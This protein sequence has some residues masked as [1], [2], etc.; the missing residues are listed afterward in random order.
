MP[1][2]VA[3]FL[4]V[5]GLFL[6]TVFTV[7][8]S[9]WNAPLGRDDAEEVTATYSS[10]RIDYDYDRYGNRRDIQEVEL[11]F[12]DHDE[13][14]IDGSCVSEEVKNAIKELPVGAELDMLLHP[15]S[16]SIVELKHGEKTILPFEEAVKDLGVE[17]IGFLILG[18]LLYLCA[19]WGAFVLLKRWILK[20]KN[21][22][23]LIKELVDLAGKQK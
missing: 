10:Y 13:L 12:T 1:N 9:Y 2:I 16:S 7:G 17:R 14:S 11:Q 19:V 22:R 8:M 23:K 18:I 15:N 4:L 3:L 20:V 6:G 21:Q 5:V